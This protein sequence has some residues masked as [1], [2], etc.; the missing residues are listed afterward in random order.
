[1]VNST[2][3]CGYASDTLVRLSSSVRMARYRKENSGVGPE[4]EVEKVHDFQERKVER[5]NSK[6]EIVSNC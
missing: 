1:M 2:R 4:L 3:V 5:D 6:S